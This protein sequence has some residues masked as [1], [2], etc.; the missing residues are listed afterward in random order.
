MGGKV[1]RSLHDRHTPVCP[2]ISWFIDGRYQSTDVAF[3]LCQIARG[4]GR[5][6]VRTTPPQV[7][8]YN[9]RTVATNSSGLPIP[10]PPQIRRGP[11]DARVRNS[12]RAEI[13]GLPSHHVVN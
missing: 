3:P 8:S 9:T 6:D 1:L 10:H 4:L 7:C 2:T 5:S 12:G 13:L 11:H